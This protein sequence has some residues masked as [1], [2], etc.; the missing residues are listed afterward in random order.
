[1]FSFLPL[2]GAGEIGASCFY[3]NI[4]GTGIILD[5]GMHPQKKGMDALPSFELIKNKP[6]DYVLISHA[7]QDHLA[8]LPFL[9]QKHP[10]L[11]IV[12][13]PQTRALA[14]KTLHDSISIWREQVKEESFKIYSHEEVDLLIQSIE[15]KAYGEVF[16]LKGYSHSSSD[17]IK[18]TFF[19]A[20]HILG[21]SGILLELNDLKVFY[22]GDINLSPQEIL[23]GAELPDIPVNTVITETT[24][25]STDSFSLKSWEEEKERFAAEANKI[26]NDGGSLLLPVFSLGKT[27]E[28]LVLIYSLI[29]KRKLIETDIYTGGLGRKISRIYDY[30]RFVVNYKDTDFELT[31]IPQKNIYDITDH[32]DFFKTPSIV[33][34]PGGMMLDKTISY[35]LGKKWLGIK[36][37]AIFTVGYM[38]ETTPG[39]KIANSKKGDKIILS[40]YE[41]PLE[42]KCTIQNFR[43]GAHSK[44]EE[45][46]EIVK[47]LKAENV[48]LVHGDPG[49]VD[50][51][52]ANIIKQNKQIKVYASQRGK[53]LIIR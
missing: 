5:C 9:I 18:V 13:T 14:E 52:G 20:G 6:V 43:F 33:L 36:D 42:I 30:N 45:L 32:N 25:G 44:R 17:E 2:G 22:T 48:I 15:Y 31:S 16:F 29:K 7:H 1:M 11:R 4:S 27:Q 12:A 53:E 40:D 8:A 21:S 50:W 49:S 38:E 3:L 23:T 37:S 46:I 24:Y 51:V 28:M 39:Y 41:T 47:R 19:D 10:Y 35:R 34:A 26:L